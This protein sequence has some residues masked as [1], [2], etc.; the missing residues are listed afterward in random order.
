MDETPENRVQTF[1]KGELAGNAT[2]KSL[3]LGYPPQQSGSEVAIIE[4]LSSENILERIE[5]R[6][7]GFRWSTKKGWIQYREPVMNSL[8]I[9]NMMATLQAISD[10]VIYS[11]FDEKEPNKLAAL[12][13]EQNYPHF[14]IYHQEFGLDKKDFN[15]IKSILLFYALSILKS[16]KNA[17]HRNVVRGTLSESVFMRA[18]GQGEA[19]K[20][21]SFNP[22]NIFRRGKK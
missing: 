14:T 5:W 21:G 8:G 3:N 4:G 9:G 12:Y 2:R 15:I 17:G 10:D 7:K 6:L 13:F 11:N 1:V 19:D 16:A 20:K 22:L 18:M